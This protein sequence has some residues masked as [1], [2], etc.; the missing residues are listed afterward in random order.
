MN[1]GGV[2][3]LISGTNQRTPIRTNPRVSP[4]LLQAVSAQCRPSPGSSMAARPPPA[5]PPL[6]LPADSAPP[7]AES[8]SR[9]PRPPTMTSRRG[10]PMGPPGRRRGLLRALGGRPIG[11]RGWGCAE[12][13]GG[14]MGRG[15]DWALRLRLG[16]E[17]LGLGIG[18]RE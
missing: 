14:V 11:G 7:A 18:D 10:E 15:W 8:R 17:D 1:F 16:I 3:A 13:W 6:S 9:P 2:K 4:S 5:P 12:S